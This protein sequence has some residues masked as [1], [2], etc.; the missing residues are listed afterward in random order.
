MARRLLRLST[1]S[2][3]HH[4]SLP[5]LSSISLTKHNY[6]GG[7]HFKKYYPG[8]DMKG[9]GSAFSLSLHIFG[10]P[11]HQA[12]QPNAHP[13][14]RPL[15]DPTI[16]VPQRYAPKY[17]D[18]ERQIE[19]AKLKQALSDY[20]PDTHKPLLPKEQRLQTS[21]TTT[22]ADEL[23]PLTLTDQEHELIETQ[24]RSKFMDL[25]TDP[26]TDPS[27]MVKEYD[28]NSNAELQYYSTPNTQVLEFHTAET[29]GR[30]LV[31]EPDPVFVPDE[32]W[33]WEDNVETQQDAQIYEETVMDRMARKGKH[34][35]MHDIFAALLQT[36]MTFFQPKVTIMYPF[37]KGP[38]SP[39]YR[40]EHALRRYPSGEER[41]IACRLCELAC[42]ARAI[43]IEASERADG[44]RRT[45]RYDID[46]TKCIFC[47]FCESACPVGAIVETPN[48][49]YATET[50]EELLYNKDKLLANG[51]R[52]E[53]ELQQN[54]RW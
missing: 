37:E 35:I 4:Q 40:G 48:F 14:S 43:T 51:D 29:V 47:G 46:L 44:S 23:S 27:T 36:S 10:G 9:T 20:S 38:V 5:Y 50:H 13:P 41:C 7:R 53:P 1:N 17:Q 6:H 34:Y 11:G 19:A 42:P 16:M 31:E 28:Y 18:Y 22:T 2:T 45:T 8:G 52:W 26:F 15:G 32:H 3:L 30:P 39:R 49:E 21:E 12:G 33:V 25:E 54:L 24:R